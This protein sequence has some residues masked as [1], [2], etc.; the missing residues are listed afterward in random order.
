MRRLLLAGPRSA[1]LSLQ[2]RK[3]QTD[4]RQPCQTSRRPLLAIHSDLG[5]TRQRSLSVGGLR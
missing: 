1:T 3:Q 5:R 2:A 4:V